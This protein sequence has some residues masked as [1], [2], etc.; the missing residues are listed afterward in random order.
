VWNGPRED[1]LRGEPV[2]GRCRHTPKSKHQVE[3]PSMVRLVLEA[4][5]RSHFHVVIGVPA[6]V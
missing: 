5:A 1:F 2:D 4:R 6:G 3:L